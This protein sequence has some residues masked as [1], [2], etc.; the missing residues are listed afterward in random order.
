[1]LKNWRGRNSENTVNFEA[2]V[3][4]EV[5][6]D[7]FRNGIIDDPYFRFN[8]TTLRW[9]ALDNWTYE[10]ELEWSQSN[11]DKQMLILEGIDTVAEFVLNGA[12]VGKTNNQFR[13]YILDI[14]HF[15]K[16]GVNKL[17][18]RFTSAIRYALDKSLEY[19]YKVPDQFAPEQ[20][21][22][23][24]RNFVRKNQCSFS[25]DWGP[26]FATMGIYKPVTFV[27]LDHSF[28]ISS[29]YH[30][31]S[32]IGQFY[33]VEVHLELE[34]SK[35]F[36]TVFSDDLYVELNISGVA[37]ARFKIDSAIS[38]CDLV[39]AKDKVELWWPNGY[40]EQK[41]YQLDADL[42][43]KGVAIQ[44][45]TKTIGFREVKLIQEPYKDQE[46][47]SF[48]FLVNGVRIF[49]KGSNWIP[50]DAFETR[51]KNEKTRSPVT[52]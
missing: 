7:L 18:V 22:E 14:T 30:T 40:G 9:I 16:S 32:N 51:V 17:E 44:R 28:Y 12:V 19:S 47:T 34:H 37:K 31:L 41:L 6:T 24:H 46:G 35:I 52:D 5:H 10:C 8:D 1:M 2:Q 4:G 45:Q 50:V 38:K 43:L 20:S 26:C 13:M 27:E 29:F 3:P 25:W 15:I 36:S 48:Y 42:Q 23:R 21:G 33:L 39:I 11:S 49:A